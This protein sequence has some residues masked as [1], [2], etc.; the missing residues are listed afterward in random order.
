MQLHM[1]CKCIPACDNSR[2][3][4]HMICKYV[5]ACDNHVYAC[6]HGPIY[7]V[8]WVESYRWAGLSVAFLF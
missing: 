2:V 7:G 6:V 8:G 1:A 3:F 4:L 5:F